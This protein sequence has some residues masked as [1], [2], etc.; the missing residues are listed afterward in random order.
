[1]PSAP[2]VLDAN[3]GT[4]FVLYRKDR[5]RCIVGA[6]QLEEYRLKPQSPTRRV[7]AACCN[8]PMFLDFTKGHWLTFYRNRFGANAPAVEMRVMANERP[9]GVTRSLDVKIG[10][11]R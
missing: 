1:M 3:G 2:P 10:P 5:I 6:E 11:I 9:S 8:S 4:G 7:I